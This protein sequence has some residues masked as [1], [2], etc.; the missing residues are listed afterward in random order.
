MLVVQSA[1]ARRHPTFCENAEGLAAVE[2]K[3]R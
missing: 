2:L 1:T 3:S